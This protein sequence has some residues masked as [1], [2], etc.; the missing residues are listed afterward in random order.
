MQNFDGTLEIEIAGPTL[1]TQY[2]RVVSTDTA[3][4]S[5]TLDVTFLGGF[6][7]GR[8]TTFNVV[9]ANN[10]V[11]AFTFYNLPNLAA[12]LV[13]RITKTAN[14][15]TLTVEGGDYNHNGIVDMADYVMWRATRNTSVT[16]GTG[17]DGDGNGLVN[18]NDYLVWRSNFG[19]V[20]GV[21]SGSGSGSLEAGNVPEPTAVVLVLCGGAGIAFLR[22][23]QRP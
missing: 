11:G 9:N 1:D 17:A 21:G 2:D 13:W 4:L 18:D 5:G 3:Y 6:S 15:F 20:R 19:R 14:A 10:I 16:P 8:N 23:R 22:R 12:G 7:P